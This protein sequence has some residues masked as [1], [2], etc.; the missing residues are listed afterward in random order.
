MKN[1]MGDARGRWEGNTLV[2]ETTNF[3]P[4]I[5]FRGAQRE[6]QDDRALH[7]DQRQHDQWEIRFDDP[8]TWEQ[9]WTYAMPLKRDAEQRPTSTPATKATAGSRTS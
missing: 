5:A 8:D 9:S 6:A 1:Y 7:A 2:V 3:H 4:L